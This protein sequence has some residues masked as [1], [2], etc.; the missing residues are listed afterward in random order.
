MKIDD[1]VKDSIIKV[2]N[3]REQT[4]YYKKEFLVFIENFIS[5]NYN[6][7]DILDIIESVKIE[8]RES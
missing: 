5:D 3:E 6:D 8:G 2:L 7:D 4:D 1:K